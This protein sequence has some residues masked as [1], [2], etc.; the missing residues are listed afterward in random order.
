MTLKSVS[1]SQL[2]KLG[3]CEIALQAELRAASPDN[4]V[5]EVRAAEGVR[6]HEQRHAS[7]LGAK[8]PSITSAAPA[9]P[10]VSLVK[11]NWPLRLVVVAILAAASYFLG[12]WS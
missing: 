2:A 3:L 6:R 1:A 4:P 7:L 12:F 10:A 9:S 8:Q 5:R 11:P